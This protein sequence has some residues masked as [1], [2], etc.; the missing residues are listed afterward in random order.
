MLWVCGAKLVRVVLALRVVM[1]LFRMSR[2]EK[3][4]LSFY[5]EVFLE[6]MQSLVGWCWKRQHSLRQVPKNYS[7]NA[8]FELKSARAARSKM[9]NLD[10]QCVCVCFTCISQ[11]TNPTQL[12]TKM[13]KQYVNKNKKNAKTLGS[14]VIMYCQLFYVN[15]T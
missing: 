9:W 2:Q 4:L 11:E 15:K 14:D 1:F 5:Y 6:K 8:K 7:Y 12:S 10:A 3:Q 13:Q